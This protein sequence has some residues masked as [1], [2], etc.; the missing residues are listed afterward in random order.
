MSLQFPGDVLRMIMALSDPWSQYCMGLTCKEL[1]LSYEGLRCNGNQLISHIWQRPK[2]S[3]P[4]A[5]EYDFPLHYSGYFYEVASAG[6][7]T[8][9][10]KIEAS[11][12]N[13]TDIRGYDF[14][15]IAYNT[16]GW[17]SELERKLVLLDEYWRVQC[18]KKKKKYK[19]FIDGEDDRGCL[20]FRGKFADT[21]YTPYL[22]QS[23]REIKCTTL[24]QIKQSISGLFDGGNQESTIDADS[25]KGYECIFLEIIPKEW[26]TCL[27]IEIRLLDCMYAV[28]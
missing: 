26:K 8:G 14:V 11:S 10:G 25:K 23:Y 28:G 9:A 1:A 22:R 17:D 15:G 21:N 2:V 4:D 12:L 20:K 24:H 16:D 19:S 6:L 18:K 27:S 7:S 5:D 3:E 13:F